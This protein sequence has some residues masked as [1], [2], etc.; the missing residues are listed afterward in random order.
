VQKSKRV[1]RRCGGG[2][3]GRSGGR[4][5]PCLG[6]VAR[7]VDPCTVGYLDEG[8]EL[9]TEWIGFVG[10]GL[11]LEMGWGSGKKQVSLDRT[12]DSRRLSGARRCVP[13]QDRGRRSDSLQVCGRVAEA[14]CWLGGLAL[15]R[16][17]ATR[18]REKLHPSPF[19]F[20]QGKTGELQGR[21]AG[22]EFVDERGKL[23]G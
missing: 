14:G 15:L 8:L 12:R 22:I 3:C 4:G 6:Q 17:A 5:C 23:R 21:V 13:R 1:C 20:P 9:R 10:R 2:S 11:K 19:E 18:R 7:R 16:V